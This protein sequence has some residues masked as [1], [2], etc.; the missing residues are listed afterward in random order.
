MAWDS[1]LQTTTNLRNSPLAPQMIRPELH[2]LFQ[3][4]RP[5]VA[6]Q[7]APSICQD[8]PRGWARNFRTWNVL[9]YP[10]M[11]RMFTYAAAEVNNFLAAFTNSV[12]T[13]AQSELP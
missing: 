12:A 11:V 6:R 4:P 10:G 13:G 5:E 7:L 8:I 3:S 2:N 1:R 9:R